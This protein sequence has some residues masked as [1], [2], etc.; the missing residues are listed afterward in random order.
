MLVVQGV[1]Q[2]Q[3]FPLLGAEQ[4]HEP[5]HDRQG[6][7]VKF[8]FLDFREFPPVVLVGPVERLDEN[9]DGLADLIAKLVGDFLLVGR[10]LGE[11]GFQRLVF[12][13]SKNRCKPSRVRKA[14]RVIGSSSQREAYHEA[15]P[16]SALS[17][18][19]A[20]SVRRW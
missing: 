15:K 13:T 12:A 10:T 9:F 11:Q 4:E 17:Y 1:A 19:P 7:F 3:E 2:E 6:G 8:G 14:R 20:S 5:H 16:V 18:R